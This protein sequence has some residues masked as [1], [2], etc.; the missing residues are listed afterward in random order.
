MQTELMQLATTLFVCAVVAGMLD[1][2]FDFWL[3][4]IL[5][6]IFLVL[7]AVSVLIHITSLVESPCKPT[8]QIESVKTS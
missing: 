7:A 3:M 2:F 6:G 8:Q 4:K 5:A 1:Y